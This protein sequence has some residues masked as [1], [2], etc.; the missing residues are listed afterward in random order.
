MGFL[1]MPVVTFIIGFA[2]GLVLEGELRTAY[3]P[4]PSGY[5]L[6]TWVVGTLS[7]LALSLTYSL[8]ELYV[9][10]Y[11]PL[12]N[13]ESY[14]QILISKER[15]QCRIDQFLSDV[16]HDARRAQE[17]LDVLYGQG[18]GNERGALQ[19]NKEERFKREEE[20]LKR[21]IRDNE[22]E[23]FKYYDQ[24]STWVPRTHGDGVLRNRSWYHYT[25]IH[26]ANNTDE[27]KSA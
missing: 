5:T 14:I 15:L 12:Q 21:E 13:M 25:N 8:A 1:I 17:E 18:L 3:N 26:V 6:L 7:G 20:Q 10:R 19:S 9:S 4:N 23:F 24:L 2:S 11:R 16:A 22:R 27:K